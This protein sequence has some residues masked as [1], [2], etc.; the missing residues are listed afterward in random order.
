[1]FREKVMK[2][3]EVRRH[4]M[5]SQAGEH[6]SQEGVNLAR[7]VGT[8]MGPFDAVITSTLPRSFETAIAMGFAVDKQDE[9]LNIMGDEVTAEIHWTESFARFAGV[10]GQGGATAH[11]A[12]E[13]A[14]F[15]KLIVQSLPENGKGLIITHGGIIEAGAVAC[16]PE[17]QH[18]KWGPACG[19]CEGIALTFDDG[20]FTKGEILRV[21]NRL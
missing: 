21:N 9:Q 7:R 2:Y 17:D 11:F 20:R 10:I 19:Y 13:Q 4:S 14:E 18:S 15:W 6:L 3:L 12:H 1:L 5:R 16:L 8:E